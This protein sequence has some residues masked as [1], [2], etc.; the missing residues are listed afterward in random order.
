MLKGLQLKKYSNTDPCFSQ[1]SLE[2]S[3]QRRFPK[4]L[5]DWRSIAVA[6]GHSCAEAAVPIGHISTH[7]VVGV[8]REP[9]FQFLFQRAPCVYFSTDRTNM[10]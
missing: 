3:C 4:V 6:K 2:Y 1:C 9:R 5:T 7:H 8:L 10:T